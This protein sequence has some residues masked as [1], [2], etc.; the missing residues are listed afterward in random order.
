M[1]DWVKALDEQETKQFQWALK[2]LE[3]WR[4]R[5]LHA[6]ESTEYFDRLI[7]LFKEAIKTGFV[8]DELEYEIHLGMKFK[9]LVENGV[10]EE[11]RVA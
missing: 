9:K 10:V 1:S 7:Q 5:L 3:D 8:S 4:P 6:Q 2:S 11:E